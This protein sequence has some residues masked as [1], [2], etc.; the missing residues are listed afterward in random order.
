M[1]DLEARL[2]EDMK[3]A[4]RE[5]NA[6][7]RGVIQMIRSQILLE[8]KKGSH[9]E[10]DDARVLRLIHGHA[11]KVREAL[12][13]AEKAARQDLAE[14]ARQELAILDDYLPTALGADELA[15]IVDE[16]V[17]GQAD[18]GPKAMGAVIKEVLARA[19]GRAD[20]KTVQAAV[21]KGLDMGE[22]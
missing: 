4:L 8:R 9:E 20:G 6:L 22:S 10:I 2:N 3:T 1:S 16:V 15:R 18:R 11:K 21:R 7:R 19:G 5:R 13:Q 12:E 17:A 14:Q